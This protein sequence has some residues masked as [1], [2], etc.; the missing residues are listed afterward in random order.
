MAMNSASIDDALTCLQCE[1]QAKYRL[2]LVDDELCEKCGQVIERAG[3]CEL[4]ICS[5]SGGKKACKG[6]Y[7]SIERFKIS[8][9]TVKADVFM[10][11]SECSHCGTRNDPIATFFGVVLKQ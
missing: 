11:D 9:N 10:E 5:L 6:T 8:G 4:V 3:D 1:K 7:W 2:R